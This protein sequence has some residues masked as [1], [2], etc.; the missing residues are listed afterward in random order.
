MEDEEEKFHTFRDKGNKYDYDIYLN[1]VPFVTYFSGQ[2][3]FLERQGGDVD[4]IMT[5]FSTEVLD[6]IEEYINYGKLLIC[7]SFRDMFNKFKEDGLTDYFEVSEEVLQNILM[8]LN[9]DS[10]YDEDLERRTMWIRIKL[11]ERWA[12]HNDNHNNIVF[13][14][15]DEGIRST[16]GNISRTSDLFNEFSEHIDDDTNLQL[17]MLYKYNDF[18]PDLFHYAGRNIN[19]IISQ[20]RSFTTI[21][22]TISKYFYRLNIYTFQLNTDNSGFNLT[23]SF[24]TKALRTKVFR[25]SISKLTSQKSSG[26]KD[27]HINK[28]PP[29]RRALP[30]SYHSDDPEY[31]ILEI[32]GQASYSIRLYLVFSDTMSLLLNPYLPY[33]Y[34]IVIDEKDKYIATDAW[35]YSHLTNKYLVDITKFKEVKGYRLYILSMNEGIKFHNTV[36][37]DWSEYDYYSDILKNLPFIGWRINKF[38]NI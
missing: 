6:I 17:H 21:P 7:D 24:S 30:K 5:G 35:L 37:F 34:Q 2:I 12:K 9:Y 23:S 29:G 10:Q 1:R 19:G 31:Y 8:I 33:W 4:V 3:D 27:I 36:N 38:V 13:D 20:Y 18:N 32:G 25:E 22:M 26:W 16:S 15:D 28:G 11:E 14:L